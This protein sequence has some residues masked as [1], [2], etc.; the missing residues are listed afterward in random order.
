MKTV[1]FIQADKNSDMQAAFKAIA[2]KLK[3]LG[4]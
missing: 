4:K 3:K 2:E 1:P